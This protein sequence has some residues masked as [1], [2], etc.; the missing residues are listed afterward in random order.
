M[1]PETPPSLNQLILLPLSSSQTIQQCIPK[2]HSN[3]RLLDSARTVMKAV[4]FILERLRRHVL[5]ACMSF[6]NWK[7]SEFCRVVMYFIVMW[8]K[9]NNDCNVDLIYILIYLVYWRMAE[10]QVAVSNLPAWCGTEFSSTSAT[11]CICI[12]VLKH[13]Y[14]RIFYTPEAPSYIVKIF[15]K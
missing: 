2:V 11:Y 5:C 8:A 12:V 3:R 15:L 14:V 1:L 4:A 6:A 13:L 10:A 9:E 7:L